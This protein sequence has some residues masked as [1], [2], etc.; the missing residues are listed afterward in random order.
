MNKILIIVLSAFLSTSLFAAKSTM[1]PKG[2]TTATH[3]ASAKDTGSTTAAA[4]GL[5][6]GKRANRTR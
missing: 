1:N 5:K 4:K 6:K 3:A 2:T